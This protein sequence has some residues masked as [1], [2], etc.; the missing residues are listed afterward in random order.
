MQPSLADNL[1]NAAIEGLLLGVPVV[2][3]AGASLDELIEPGATGSSFRWATWTRSRSRS[4]ASGAARPPLAR[5]SPGARRWPR[6]CARNAPCANLLALAGL[7][8]E[9]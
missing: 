5:A 7:G 1:P 6:R 4:C 9:R 2:A 3:F 8:A